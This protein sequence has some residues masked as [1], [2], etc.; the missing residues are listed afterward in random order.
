MITGIIAC[1]FFADSI[2]V[3]P[4]NA[5]IGVGET[6]D[7]V[8]NPV[9]SKDVFTF[10]SSD[11]HVASVDA[12]GTVLGVA[13]GTVTITVTGSDSGKTGTS[14]ITV[15][16]SSENLT[17]NPSLESMTEGSEGGVPYSLATLSDGRTFK[18][19]DPDYSQGVADMAPTAA[20]DFENQLA[21]GGGGNVY[22]MLPLM[23][24]YGVPIQTIHPYISRGDYENYTQSGDDPTLVWNDWES[25]TYS[26]ELVN[27]YNTVHESSTY[28]IPGNF[29]VNPL[30]LDALEKA[31]YGIT[32]FVTI[33]GDELRSPEWYERQLADGK[34]IVIALN[35]ITDKDED[36]DILMPRDK[37][38]DESDGWHAVLIAGYDRTDSDDP[39]F[40]VKNSWGPAGS[41]NFT[42]LSYDFLSDDK[43]GRITQAAY[44]TGVKDP[45]RDTFHPQI[46]LG[47]WKVMM[48][49]NIARLDIHRKS[50]FYTPAKLS[51]Q[52]DYRLGILL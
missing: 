35:W 44:I 31:A 8:V 28:Q 19:D 12:G 25:G 36:T 23:M 41:R 10:E 16:E 2:A 48:D 22:G 24:T 33:P 32:G 14:E 52:D 43:D 29:T 42:K 7:I 34:E 38:E 9:S 6:L 3:T 15:T 11:P 13:S 26:Q 37:K 21:M 30:P 4:K 39:Y 18:L 40:I 20:E 50:K 49:G 1:N 5:E 45:N 17:N 46:A 51:G 47:R 27:S